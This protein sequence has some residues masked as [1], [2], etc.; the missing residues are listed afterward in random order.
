MPSNR[1]RFV[2]VPAPEGS[3]DQVFIAMEDLIAQHM[4]GCLWGWRFWRRRP[5]A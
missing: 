2:Q 1:P 4:D 5:S 3:T